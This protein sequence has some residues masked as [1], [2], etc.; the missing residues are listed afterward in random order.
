SHSWAGCLSTWHVHVIVRVWQIR[1]P[2]LPAPGYVVFNCDG[3]HEATSLNDATALQTGNSLIGHVASGAHGHG[4]GQGNSAAAAAT[5][6]ATT[7]MC[8]GIRLRLLLRLLTIDRCAPR[9]KKHVRG[10]DRAG[11]VTGMVRCGR[12][13]IGPWRAKLLLREL[14]ALVVQAR[15]EDRRDR[16]LSQSSMGKRAEPPWRCISM[17]ILS[18]IAVMADVISMRGVT[19][20]PRSWFGP[21]NGARHE[22]R[23][24]MSGSCCGMIDAV[25]R[26]EGQGVEKKTCMRWFWTLNLATLVMFPAKRR[27]G[28]SSTPNAFRVRLEMRTPLGAAEDQAPDPGLLMLQGV[29]DLADLAGCAGIAGIAGLELSLP[30]SEDCETVIELVSDDDRASSNDIANDIG[31]GMAGHWRSNMDQGLVGKVGGVFAKRPSIA[32]KGLGRCL[33]S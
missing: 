9:P 22:Q 2:R 1:G 10:R 7:N 17:H 12:L 28:R 13:P 5:S 32:E 18:M 23:R 11:S 26:S 31:Q 27:R 25:G 33:E 6:E 20:S 15:H 14:H 30:A 4:N 24:E 29:A 8:L 19:G 3:G 21:L 16:N